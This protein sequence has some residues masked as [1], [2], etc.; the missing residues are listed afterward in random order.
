VLAA[1]FNE[2]KNAACE[3]FVGQAAPCAVFQTTTDSG[4]TWTRHPLPV[5]SSSMG[6]LWVAADPSRASHFTVAVLNSTSTQF[7]VYQTFDSGNTWSGPTVVTEDA[8]T[9]HF[10][11]WINYSAQGVLGLM[12]RSVA[13]AMDPPASDAVTANA[14]ARQCCY[15]K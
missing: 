8:T 13:P 4:V 7:L 14:V 5:P 15:R 9:V 1:T 2:T 6:T 3:Y 12:W 10:K 11:P